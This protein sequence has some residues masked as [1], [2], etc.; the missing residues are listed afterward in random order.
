MNHPESAI[1]LRDAIA[2]RDPAVIA[3]CFSEDYVTIAPQ[4]PSLSFTGRDTVL[5]NWT[6]IIARMPDITAAILRSSVNGEDIWTEWDMRGTVSD[7]G[8]DALV[9]TAIWSTD[10]GGL[11]SESRFYL[12]P[13]N[14]NAPRAF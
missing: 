8:P 9:G 5:R 1:R 7:G 6:A 13:V 11:I 14:R 12:A 10:E 4:N 3:A 2:T